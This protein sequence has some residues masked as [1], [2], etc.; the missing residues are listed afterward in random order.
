MILLL[1]PEELTN[2]SP[3]GRGFLTNS[4]PPGPTRSQIPDNCH[5]YN[6]HNKIHN[7]DGFHPQTTLSL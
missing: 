3:Q 4:P 5:K 6:N 1:L 2:A 7:R